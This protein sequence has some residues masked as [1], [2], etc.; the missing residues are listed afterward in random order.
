MGVHHLSFG[1]FWEPFSI[2]INKKIDAEIDAE[3]VMKMEEK[4]CENGAEC[5]RKFD[6]FRKVASRKNAFSEKGV[7]TQ[8]IIFMQ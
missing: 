1:P 3:K 6:K 7:N 8:T 4:R 5:D 2:K